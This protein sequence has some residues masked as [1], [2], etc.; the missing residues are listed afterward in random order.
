MAT[1]VFNDNIQ[2]ALPPKFI[3]SKDIDN[4]GKEEVSIRTGEYKD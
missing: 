3:Y 2:F 4:E 1:Y